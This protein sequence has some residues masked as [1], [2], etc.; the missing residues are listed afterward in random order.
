MAVTRDGSRI[1]FAQGVE[2]PSPRLTYIMTAWDAPSLN[3]A[4]ST[5]L[6]K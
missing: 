5:K 1:L 4:P 2:Q 6:K 3:S